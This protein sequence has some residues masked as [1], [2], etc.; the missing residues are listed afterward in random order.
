MPLRCV[1]IC[2]TKSYAMNKLL[3]IE[4]DG[5]TLEM[6]GCLAD[7]LNI[8]VVLKPEIPTIAEIQELAPDL[9]LLDYW[10]FGKKGDSFCSAIKTNKLTNHIPIVM[11]SAVNKIGEIAMNCGADGCIS[12][13]F[14]IDM[15]QDIFQAY[16]G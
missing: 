12:K 15:L 11:M 13:P 10:V 9:I 14:D 7:S 3:I 16:L 5:D 4:D 6:L 8:T 2:T 1:Y